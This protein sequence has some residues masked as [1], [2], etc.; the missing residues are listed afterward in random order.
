MNRNNLYPYLLPGLINAEW[1]SICLPIGHG[2]HAT[3]FE[4]HESDAGIVHTTV[5]PDTLR[6]A[7]LTTDE[8]HQIA[9][10]NLRR[11]ADDDPRLA[12]LGS[13]LRPPVV[14]GVYAVAIG[15]GA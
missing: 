7:G 4:D 1:G 13:V 10:D 15:A 8:A 12:S 5:N 6:A 11:F 2:V 14:L 9:L 3:L